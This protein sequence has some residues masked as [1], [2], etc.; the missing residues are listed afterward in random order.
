MRL[1]H[2]ESSSMAA[3]LADV[4]NYLQL[5]DRFFMWLRYMI[6]VLTGK[7]VKM[8][9]SL[10]GVL[11]VVCGAVLALSGCNGGTFDEIAK[12][13]VT[14]EQGSAL[15]RAQVASCISEKL[16]GFGSNLGT[17]PDID[18]GV[19][20]LELGGDD[21]GHFRNYYLIDV[22]DQVHGSSVSVRRSKSPDGN[23][24]MSQLRDLIASCVR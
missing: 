6:T 3:F 23:L 4:P 20:R 13:P 21:A 10:L 12:A 11:P 2:C 24:S 7:A 18:P 1:K 15:P 9:R 16:S 19:T 14:F 8:K 22:L 17:F 5:R